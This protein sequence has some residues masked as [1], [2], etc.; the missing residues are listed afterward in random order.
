MKSLSKLKIELENIEKNIKLI[1]EVKQLSI[2]RKL[3]SLK[4]YIVAKETYLLAQKIWKVNFTKKVTIGIGSDIGLCSKYN[5][6]I[7]QKSLNYYLGIKCQ[8]QPHWLGK[9]NNINEFKKNIEFIKQQRICPIFAFDQD[10]LI[11]MTYTL[12]DDMCIYDCDSKNI[13]MFYDIFFNYIYWMSSYYENNIRFNAT[14]SI[15]DNGKKI[16]DEMR[17]HYYRT[18]QSLQNTALIALNS[19][20]D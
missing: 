10:F 3:T 15:L 11:E 18:R 6:N 17:N 7:K 1:D 5:I 8:K 12:K 19:K 20:L 4:K 14:Q 16:K 2:I 9:N 13:D